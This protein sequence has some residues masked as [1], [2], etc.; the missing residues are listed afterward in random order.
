MRHSVDVLARNT[1]WTLARDTSLGLDFVAVNFYDG[2][3]FMVKTNLNVK[4]VRELNSA[5]VCVQPGTTHELNLADYFRTN[6]MQLNPVVIEKMEDGVA[7]YFAG[8]CD[9]LTADISGLSS[10]RSAQGADASRH[11]DLRCVAISRTTSPRS[12]RTG[13][14]KLAKNTSRASGHIPSKRAG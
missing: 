8:R 4:S 9:A 2:Q 1:T 7:A 3:G 10:T 6:R 5:T 13:T 14:V 12:F 11:V